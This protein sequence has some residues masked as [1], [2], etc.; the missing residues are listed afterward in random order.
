MHFKQKENKNIWELP[1]LIKLK[2]N[3]RDKYKILD[4][5]KSLQYEFQN[6]SSRNSIKSEQNLNFEKRI[7]KLKISIFEKSL[8]FFEFL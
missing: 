5:N 8:M 3:Q 1:N 7:F 4:W 2:L 6:S